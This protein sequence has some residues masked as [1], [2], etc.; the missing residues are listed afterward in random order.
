MHSVVHG[1]GADRPPGRR[2]WLRPLLITVGFGGLLGIAVACGGGQHAASDEGGGSN[3]G[4]GNQQQANAAPVGTNLGLVDQ[5]KQIF[6]SDTFGDEGFWSGTLQ[7]DKV[8]AGGQ[9]GGTGPGVSPKTALSVGLK[10]DVDA[11]PASVQQAIKAGQVN[12]DDPGVTL[13]LLKLNSVVGLRGTFNEN[14]TLRSLGVTCAV[15]HSTVDN[16]FAPGIGHRLDG[17]PNRDLNTGAI[18]NLAP[19]DGLQPVA[20]ILGVDVDT[21]RT[22]LKSWGPGKFDAELFMDGK[23]FRPDGKSAATLIPPAYGLAG[24]NLH[25]FTGWGSVTQWN[26]FV[27]NLE[28]HGVGTY[29]D[30]RLDNSSQ[31]PVAAKNNF[32]HVTPPKGQQDQIT[33]KLAALAAYEEVLVAPKPPDKSFDPKAAQRGATLFMGKAGCASCHVPPLFTEPGQNLHPGSDIGIDD[34]Q[35]DRSPTHMYR[36]TPLKGLWAH[37]QGGFYHDGRFA[38]LMDVVDHYNSVKNLGLTAQEKSDLVQYLQSL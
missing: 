19:D 2:R 32:G 15:C 18:V 29:Y 7:L 24:V 1:V 20:K 34:F 31:F 6:R 28:M 23:A 17:W 26:A 14:G 36:T 4:P 13:T 25:T 33:P 5:G 8:I 9:H 30:T 37:Q 22:V 27:A 21:V 10:V 16:S 3:Q 35:A 12:L 38:T 11:L